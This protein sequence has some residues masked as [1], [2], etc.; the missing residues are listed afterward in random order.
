MTF[1]DFFPRVTVFAALA[2]LSGVSQAQIGFSHNW[3]EFSPADKSTAVVFTNEGSQ[4]IELEFASRLRDKRSAGQRLLVYPPVT[5]LGPGQ[6]QTI[7]VMAQAVDGS[8]ARTPAFFWLDY[9]YKNLEDAETPAPAPGDTAG[10]V[11]LRTAV[12]LPV[13]YVANGAKPRAAARVLPADDGS[14]R[15][16]VI[17]NTGQAAL[18]V[19]QM[20]RG[21]VTAPLKLTILPGDSALVE[22]GGLAPP[23]RF[24]AKNHPEIDVL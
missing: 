17:A 9:R 20:Q 23:F 24:L 8:P 14:V 12:S 6:K 22:T 5:R 2:V 7:R 15:G 18:R 3:L 19:H 16:I 10:R 21:A 4:A 11:S 1:F 13:S